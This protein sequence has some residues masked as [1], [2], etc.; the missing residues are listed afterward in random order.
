MLRLLNSNQKNLI[1]N[2]MAS[3]YQCPQIA[4][5][6]FSMA[7]FQN[8]SIQSLYAVLLLYSYINYADI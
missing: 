3:S 2:S 6:E 4:Y 1:G 8:V 5:T 7:A